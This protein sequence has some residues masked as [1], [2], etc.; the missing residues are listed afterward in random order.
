M[1][2][3]MNDNFVLC[4]TKLLNMPIVLLNFIIINV[5]IGRVRIITGF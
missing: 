1:I 5:V 4:D 2:K 3:A